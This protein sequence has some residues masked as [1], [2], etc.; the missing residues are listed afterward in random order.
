MTLQEENKILKKHL[1]T[2]YLNL[3]YMLQDPGD[4]AIVDP[5]GLEDRG[6]I[7]YGKLE[8]IDYLG[9]SGKSKPVDFEWCYNHNKL[10]QEIE[11]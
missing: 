10:N 2:L 6:T 5:D 3:C 7:K 1:T 8:I 11:K 4:N 9:R